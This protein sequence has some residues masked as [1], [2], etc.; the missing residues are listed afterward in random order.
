MGQLS[1]TNFA[2]TEGGKEKHYCC[3][4]A[5]FEQP[6]RVGDKSEKNV[7]RHFANDSLCRDKIGN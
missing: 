6:C 2:C 7:Y 3:T 5:L 4:A 1:E